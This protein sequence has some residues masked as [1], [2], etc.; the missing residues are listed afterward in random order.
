MHEPLIKYINSYATTL[1][2]LTDC[3]IELI[4]RFLFL[5]K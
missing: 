4:K 1:T 2:K 3:E 5:K